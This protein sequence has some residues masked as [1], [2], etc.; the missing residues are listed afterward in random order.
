MTFH[1]VETIGVSPTPIRDNPGRILVKIIDAGVG[2]SGFYPAATLQRAAEDRV[3]AA[4]THMYMDHAASLARGVNGERSIKDLAAVLVEDGRYDAESESVVAEAIVFSRYAPVIAELAEHIGVSISAAAEVTPGS[5]A[6]EPR[7][8]DRIVA[9]ESV[10]FVSKAGR[11]GKVLAVL[12]SAAVVDEA[13]TDDMRDRLDRAIMAAYHDPDNDVWAGIRDYDPD[14][15]TVYFYVGGALYAQTYT[16]TETDIVQLIGTK[17]EVRQVTQY[18]SVAEPPVVER[19]SSMPEIDQERLD[20]LL[21][22]EQRV[23]E[24]ETVNADLVAKVGVLE[25]E[26]LAAVR[27]RQIVEAV[28]EACAGKPEAMRAR[29]IAA[30]EAADTE[31]IPD[32]V[33]AAVEAEQSYLAAVTEKKL[34]GFGADEPSGGAAK[35]R[36]LWA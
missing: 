11:G 15:H 18:V 8:I 6:G 17:I 19:A 30:V 25:A 16:E 24:L 29:V 1:I 34:T 31:N 9:A 35:L 13:T 14:I 4:G 2:S 21:E 7:T 28:D 26:K 27:H 23:G 5:R 36:K 22:T 10:D 3:F 33:H 20:A 12:E 32:A